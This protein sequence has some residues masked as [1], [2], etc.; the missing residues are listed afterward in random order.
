MVTL[1]ILPVG[2]K[3]SCPWGNL[4]F[5]WFG[6]GGGLTDFLA[7]IAFSKFP[8]VHKKRLLPITGIVVSPVVY[9]RLGQLSLKRTSVGKFEEKLVNTLF[10]M[11]IMS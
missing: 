8:W 9:N 10:L 11:K 5:L 2:E 6:G 3:W 4:L 1:A 7:I